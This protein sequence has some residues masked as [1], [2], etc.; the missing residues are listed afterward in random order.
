MPRRNRAFGQQFGSRDMGFGHNF[1][2]NFEA[3]DDVFVIA[4]PAQIRQ[5]RWP[6]QFGRRNMGFYPNGRQTFPLY[7]EA[8]DD[9]VVI[10]PT[11]IEQVRWR[12]DDSMMTWVL[13]ESIESAISNSRAAPASASSVE[14][15]KRMD[16]TSA[17]FG[18]LTCVVCQE[19]LSENEA[20][21]QMPCS[22]VFHG[23]CIL[24]W[25]KQSHFC[26]I[27]RFEMLQQ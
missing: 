15:L 25:L 20:I 27:C 3:I 7:S 9:V 17:E 24:Q 2:F 8:I 12:N 1:S 13:N 18:D 16:Y 5:V 14:A 19:E 11:Q 21:V 10:S 22:H 6:Q 26:P 4:S 23:Q